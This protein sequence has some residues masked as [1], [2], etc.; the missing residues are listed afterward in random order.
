MPPLPQ[1]LAGPIL[2]RCTPQKVV[3]WLTTS[4]P[5]SGL[6][7][8]AIGDKKPLSA[9]DKSHINQ[10]CWPVGNYCY[11]YIIQWLPDTPLPENTIIKYNFKCDSSWLTELEP[12]LLYKGHEHLSF[13]IQLN[14]QQVFHGSCRKPHH[15]SS[16]G[17]VQVDQQLSQCLQHQT[18]RPDLL[19]M[20]GDQVYIDDVAG[21]MLVAIH[22]VIEQ[23]GLWDEEISGCKAD[24]SQALY[25]HTNTYYNR[26]RL[27]P[28]NDHNRALQKGFWKGKNKPCGLLGPCSHDL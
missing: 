21:P 16:D 9:V 8:A 15:P 3:F 25:T 11:I 20:S 23:L 7:H 13:S 22:Q 26:D 4:T 28:E 14:I 18:T 27:L 12:N 10:I 1:L 6:F 19:L 2:R 17:L 24:N 5:F